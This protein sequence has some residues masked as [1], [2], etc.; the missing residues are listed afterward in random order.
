MGFVKNFIR[1]LNVFFIIFL[2][3]CAGQRYHKAVVPAVS[4]QARLPVFAWPIDGG[5]VIHRFGAQEDG[6]TLKGIVLEGYEGQAVRS[7]FDGVVVY[8][9]ESMRGY[10]KTLIIEHADG[11]SSVYARISQLLVKVG[12]RVK[13][14]QSLARV[15]RDGKGSEPRTYFEV[16]QGARPVDPEQVLR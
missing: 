8:A 11:F 9:D 2:T 15:G 1:I 12:E 7:A 4:S 6:V 16:R 3:G 14:G 5:R 13:K 10:G